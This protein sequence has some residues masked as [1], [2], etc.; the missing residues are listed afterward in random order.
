MEKAKVNRNSKSKQKWKKEKKNRYSFVS[1]PSSPVVESVCIRRA[2]TQICSGSLMR[3]KKKVSVWPLSNF[4]FILKL[5]LL[6]F[7]CSQPVASLVRV[8]PLLP[9]GRDKNQKRVASLHFFSF[10][11]FCWTT[12]WCAPKCS[13][14]KKTQGASHLLAAQKKTLS[15]GPRSY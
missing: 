4:F 10:F 2:T 14:Q 13:K 15:R 7:C 9:I 11:F 8:T 12:E 6:G 1:S 3:E 5:H